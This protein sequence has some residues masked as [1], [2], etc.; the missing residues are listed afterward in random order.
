MKKKPLSPNHKSKSKSKV[1]KA[2]FIR[3]LPES[4]TPKEVVAAGAKKGIK[5]SAAQVS[6]S[7]YMD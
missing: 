4:M 3:S 6:V 1:N 7:R 2:A 5:L